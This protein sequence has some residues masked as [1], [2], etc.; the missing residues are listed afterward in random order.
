MGLSLKDIAFRKRTYLSEEDIELAFNMH[1][2]GHTQ[3]EVLKVLKV[4][5]ITLNRAFKKRG[6]KKERRWLRL[7]D[8][9]AKRITKSIINGVSMVTLAKQMGKNTPDIWNYY[10][11]YEGGSPAIDF[12][13]SKANYDTLIYFLKM[14]MSKKEIAF[15]LNTNK[16]FIKLMIV[17]LGLPLYFFLLNG[18]QTYHAL[19]KR[20]ILNFISQK[21]KGK[22][23][24]PLVKKLKTS[25]VTMDK[26][27]NRTESIYMKIA[28]NG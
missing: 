1:K 15:E 19:N 16:L 10:K 8:V 22:S 25:R 20:Q 6:L 11:R 17:T 4:N 23:S 26:I 18:K 5:H 21:F 14:G 12:K 7:T 3:V 9:Q 24:A 2:D 28:I 13:P 27:L